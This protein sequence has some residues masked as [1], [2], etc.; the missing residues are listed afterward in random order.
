MPRMPFAEALIR[1]LS[2]NNVLDAGDIEAIDALPFTGKSVRS[3]QRIVAD[4]ERPS[5]CCLVI[6]GFLFRSKTTPDGQRQILSIHI[7][8]DIP[9]LHSLHLHVMDH[10]LVALTEC[11]LGFIDHGAINELC[12]IRPSVAAALWRETL[13]DAAFFREWIVNVGRR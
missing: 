4:R 6:R 5:A 10:D 11:T 9:D 13:I 7:P 2:S 1:K 3:R 12:A 8:G